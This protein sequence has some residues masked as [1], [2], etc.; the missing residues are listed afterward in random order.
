MVFQKKIPGSDRT[1]RL[2]IIGNLSDEERF[3]VE[4]TLDFIVLN[5]GLNEDILKIGS[6]AILG[7]IIA[8]TKALEKEK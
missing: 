1:V 6:L 3:F 2:E 8:C 4:K 5:L 7:S